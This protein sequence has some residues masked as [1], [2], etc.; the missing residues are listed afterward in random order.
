MTSGFPSHPQSFPH[1]GKTDPAPTALSHDSPARTRCVHPELSTSLW[2][3]PRR[4]E[5]SVETDAGIDRFAQAPQADSSLPAQC[6][7]E[8]VDK[9]L[10]M[11][12]ERHI[13]RW[14]GGFLVPPS[15][16]DTSNRQG[17]LQR[18]KRSYPQKAR[19]RNLPFPQ[20]PQIRPVL[21]GTATAGL[22]VLA[23]PWR[24]MPERPGADARALGLHGDQGAVDSARTTRI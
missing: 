4:T 17:P 8:M 20:Y 18:P 6:S 13:S 22:R 12:A 15:A 7:D 16:P 10:V 24:P 21:P 1:C 14:A 5:Q 19:V 3:Y 11:G 9:R 23:G 2:K